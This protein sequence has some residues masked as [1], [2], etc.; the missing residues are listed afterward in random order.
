MGDPELGT[1]DHNEIK[2]G[3]LFGLSATLL[4]GSYP[5]WYK[6]LAKID[7]WQLL[8]WRIVFAELFLALILFVTARHKVLR[9]TIHAI[10]WRNITVMAAVLGFWWF[11]YIYG[12]LTNRVL[13][14][15]LGYFISPLM[16]IAVSR[17]IFKEQMTRTQSL[18][19][20]FATVGVFLMALRSLS[21]TS[22]PWIALLIG[23]CFSFYGI[24]KKKVSGDPVITQTLEILLLVPF[25][26]G[27][28][29]WAHSGASLHVFL[30]DQ[31]TDLLLLATGVITV[32]PLWWY[33]RAAKQLPMVILGFLQFIPPSCNFLLGAFV[34]REP[35]DSY[36]LMVFALIWTGLAIFMYG[37][38]S[39]SREA[40]RLAKLQKAA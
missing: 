16:S 36:K 31:K 2:S 5:L 30:I 21:W 20:G 14:V 38:I 7:A 18:A 13:E 26:L 39:K 3:L 6:P 29:G 11:I 32:L 34:Y 22:I 9:E 8:S 10:S 35:L 24:F 15:A 23:S 4:W 28:L 17:L 1:Q 25:A 12:I 27:F 19:V 33:S 37:S 40:E